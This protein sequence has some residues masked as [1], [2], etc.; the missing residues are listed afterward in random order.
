MTPVIAVQTVQTYRPSTRSSGSTCVQRDRATLVVMAETGGALRSV[1]RV[2]TAI[3]RHRDQQQAHFESLDTKAGLLVGFAGAIAAL[4]KDVDSVLG[5]L[6]L[7]GAA[8]AA[9]LG[10]VSFW[11]RSYPVFDP[12]RLRQYLRAEDEFTALR[13]VDTETK[14]ALK[15]SRLIEHKARWLRWALV[16]LVGAVVLL[17]TGTVVE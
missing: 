6:G 3:H 4:A 5:K 16:V 1:E 7:V 15:A 2:L 17:A 12:R 10:I 11:P 14:M 9:V 8:A 13:L